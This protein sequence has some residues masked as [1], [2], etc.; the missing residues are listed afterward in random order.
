MLT[1]TAPATRNFGGATA[2]AKPEDVEALTQMF[3]MQPQPF[4]LEIGRSLG[5]GEKAVY[6]RVTRLRLHACRD[7]TGKLMR[8]MNHRSCGHSI[9][10]TGFGHRLC[11]DCR[12]D[13]AMVCA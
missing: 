7:G 6:A 3:M 2:N 9:V 10:S 12:H 5:R 11:Y 1:Q 8:C 4:L 13:T